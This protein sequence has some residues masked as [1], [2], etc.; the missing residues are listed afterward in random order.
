MQMFKVVPFFK[1]R[2]LQK[3]TMKKTTYLLQVG[4]ILLAR[5]W[6][7]YPRSLEKSSQPTADKYFLVLFV[8]I[9]SVA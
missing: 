2:T 8:F 7:T 6:Y 1:Q 5:D 3:E 9:M 4:S